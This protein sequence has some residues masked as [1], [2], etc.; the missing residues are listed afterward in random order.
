MY[1]IKVATIMNQYNVFNIYFVNN[2]IVYSFIH[3]F[4]YNFL[5]IYS[6]IAMNKKKKIN[7]I[8]RKIQFDIDTTNIPQKNPTMSYLTYVFNSLKT[9]KSCVQTELNHGCTHRRY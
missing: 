1:I 6:F 4:I 5:Y 7:K 3:S 2:L 9:I 8:S